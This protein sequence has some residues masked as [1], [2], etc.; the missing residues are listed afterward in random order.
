MPLTNA[1]IGRKNSQQDGPGNPA[2][3][4]NRDCEK[5]ENRNQHDRGSEVADSDRS[6]RH[7][8]P[9]DS[10]FV[11]SDEGEEQSDAGR[12]AVGQSRRE[13]VDHPLP[14]PRDRQQGEDH[15]RK[16][17]RSQRNLPAI[18]HHPHDGVS[19]KCVLA[20]VGSDREGAVRVKPHRE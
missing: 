17:Y 5:T 9:H 19:E 12:E 1:T 4:Q 6:T 8:D 11:Q 10:G 13:S 18:T 20:H 16:Q 15:T 14:N 2:Q 3:G 7:A